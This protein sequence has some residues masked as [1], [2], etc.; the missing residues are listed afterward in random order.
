M[1]KIVLALAAVLSVLAGLPCSAQIA[2]DAQKIADVAAGKIA[3]AKASWWGFDLEDSAANLQAAIDSGVPKLIVD[4]M[5]GPWIVTPMT[6]VSNQEIVF[7]EGVEVLAKRG[8]F[9][10]IGAALFAARNCEN[11][12]LIGYGATLRMWR[13][14]YGNPELYEQAEWRHCLF[15]GGCTN[16]KVYGLTL[17]ESGGDGIYLGSGAER[18][19]NTDVH[20]KDVTCERHYRQ[21]ISVINAENLLIESTILRDTAGTPPC[22]GIDFEPNRPE[23]RLVHCVMRDCE[24]SNNAG[25]LRGHLTAL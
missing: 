1:H 20:I 22:A 25:H 24:I 4:K 7:E 13:E 14:D 2:P 17:A 18:T 12:S 16:V 5:A 19:P 3:E 8:E 10:P 6:L 21:G 23:E 15:L 11:L 9:K